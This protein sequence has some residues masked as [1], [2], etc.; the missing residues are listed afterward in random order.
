MALPFGSKQVL[1]TTHQ[2]HLQKDFPRPHVQKH[3]HNVQG[4]V[5]EIT[6]KQNNQ[7]FLALGSVYISDNVLA[8]SVPS[9]TPN[10]VSSC[11]ML[12]SRGVMFR[13]LDQVV[14]PKIQNQLRTSWKVPST[15]LNSEKKSER[16][17]TALDEETNEDLIPAQKDTDPVVS[18]MVL[19]IGF[20]KNF[21]SPLLPPGEYQMFNGKFS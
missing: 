9:A 16:E 8:S 1:A 10:V 2:Q 13:V 11:I 4:N 21:I 19:T 17:G 12:F 5:F 15:F 3:R 18:S 6:S 14:L 20:Y 7:K